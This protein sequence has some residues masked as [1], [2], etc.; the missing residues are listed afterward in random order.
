MGEAMN[1][2]AWLTSCDPNA[3][4]GFL[5]GKASDRKIRLYATAWCRRGWTVLTNPASQRAVEVSEQF[6]DA[7]ATSEELEA[8]REGAR[9]QV[10]SKGPRALP[11]TKAAVAHLG[12]LSA[13]WVSSADAWDSA[14]AAG[15]W[16]GT[17][18][19][20]AQSEELTAREAQERAGI[21]RDLFGNPFRPVTPDAAWLTPTVI[22]LAQAAYEE[23]TLPSGDLDSARLAVL[24]DALEEVGCTDAVLAHLRS[25]GPHV[26]GCWALDLVLGKN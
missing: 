6:A 13:V 5:R 25:A 22:S 12:L 24:A 26:R 9:Q 14:S 21:L 23:R 8:A 1:A 19:S 17:A 2:D 20:R 11:R 7:L 15:V 18:R 3:M 16:W 4:V 10:R